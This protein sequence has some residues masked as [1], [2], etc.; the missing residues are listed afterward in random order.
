MKTPLSR[1]LAVLLAAAQPL[2]AAAQTFRAIP[3][4]T[5][6][7]AGIPSGPA[8]LPSFLLGAIDRHIA[9]AE[10]RLSPALPNVALPEARPQQA[11]Q[12]AQ[13]AAYLTRAALAA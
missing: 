11:A 3:S 10:L 9:G 4:Q 6:S 13:A 12:A 5:P 2:P 1:I 7:G 8:A